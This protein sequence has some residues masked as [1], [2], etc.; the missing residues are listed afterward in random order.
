MPDPSECPTPPGR[1]REAPPLE[2][3]GWQSVLAAATH[4]PVPLGR[5][6]RPDPRRSARPGRPRLAVAGRGGRAACSATCCSTGPGDLGA[7]DARPLAWS[8][9]ST[10]GV[11]GATWVPGLLLAAAV[12]WL[13]VATAT[14]R[15]LDL[16][17]LV[18]PAARPALSPAA[19]RRRGPPGGRCSW[20][21]RLL[22][23]F[24]AALVGPYL[25]RVIAALM[26]VFPIF[27]AL[28]L[29]ADD[30]AGAAGPP[31]LPCGRGVDPATASSGVRVGASRR[32][33]D[34]PDGL[35]LLRAAGPRR[36]PTGGPRPATRR[37]VTARRAGWAWPARRGSWRPSPLLTV[38]GA[39]RGRACRAAPR[40][41]GGGIFRYTVAVNARRRS[42]RPG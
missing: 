10:F 3:K 11:Q 27:P 13:A 35:R 41:G 5:L 32:S 29:G 36:R 9:R 22:W 31:R 7:D 20:S 14:R 16:R 21:R 28:M 26:N 40:R 12:V 2:R 33:G 18:C 39:T 34:G 38:A 19:A 25:V 4:R 8:P 23:C 30:G 6:L 15:A 42:A 37:D 1:A 17:G 24:A